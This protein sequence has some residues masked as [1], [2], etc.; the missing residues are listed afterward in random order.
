MRLAV[1]GTGYVGLVTGTCL[2]DNGND[3]CCVDIDR[4]K[5]ANLQKGLVPIYEPGNFVL[6]VSGPKGWN[7]EPKQ[8]AFTITSGSDA[9]CQ[10]LHFEFTGFSL[11]G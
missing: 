4:E 6:K 8:L 10:D 3:V 2:A 11:S 9:G 7:F 1:I 5:V